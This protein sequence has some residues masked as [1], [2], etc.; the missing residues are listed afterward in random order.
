MSFIW[1]LK[2]FYCFSL[3]SLIVLP[4]RKKKKVCRLFCSVGPLLHQSIQARESLEAYVVKMLRH[5]EGHDKRWEEEGEM[6]CQGKHLS[7]A[8]SMKAVHLETPETKAGQRRSNSTTPTLRLRLGGKEKMSQMHREVQPAEMSNTKRAPKYA[9]IPSEQE[10][11]GA[12]WV[13]LHLIWKNESSQ[14]GKV[15]TLPLRK[16]RD[17]SL[18]RGWVI[19]I[20]WNAGKANWSGPWWG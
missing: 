9:S 19:S 16:E 4:S 11:P 14:L 18:S 15:N 8:L 1:L 10:L 20:R 5:V 12:R 7:G 3:P 17:R 13:L 2:I 6:V